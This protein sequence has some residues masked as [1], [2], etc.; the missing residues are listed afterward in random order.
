MSS[1][2]TPAQATKPKLIHLSHALYNK[3]SYNELSM[4]E[5]GSILPEHKLILEELNYTTLTTFY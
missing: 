2:P 3:A 1:Q 5:T 4:H